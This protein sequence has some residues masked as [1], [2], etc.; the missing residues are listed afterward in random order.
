M[1]VTAERLDV[2]RVD[3]PTFLR[4][5]FRWNQ[6]EHVSL[7]GPTGC[8]KTTLGVR[9]LP[10]RRYVA[11]FA[12]KNRDDTMSGLLANGYRRIDEWPPPPRDN[13][14]VLWPQAPLRLFKNPET[15]ELLK[16]QQSTFADAL[17]DMYWSGGWAVYVDEA[18][19]LDTFLGL[20]RP[21]N[22]LLGAGRSNN[23]SVIMGT[24]RPVYVTRSMF[25]E[26]THLFLWRLTDFQDRKRL[27]EISGGVDKR[28]I[29]EEV[30][31]LSKHDVL[32]VNTRLGTVVTTR[33]DI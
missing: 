30:A 27:L 28:R 24:Q 26:A 23:V 14:V 16:A 9:I 32:Y 21:I 25:S 13:R 8:G 10:Y 1:S 20:R 12:T 3:W 15:S 2:D 33:A 17:E 22:L 6:G 5:I 31:G 29:M 11:A 18:W 7:I 19:Y 4:E